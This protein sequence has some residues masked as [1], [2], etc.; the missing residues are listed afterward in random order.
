MRSKK[1]FLICGIPMLIFYVFLIIIFYAFI[2]FI[3][4]L[5][6]VI[7]GFSIIRRKNLYIRLMKFILGCYLIF[8]VLIPNPYYMF[9]EIS[10]RV[11]LD[12]S[13]IITPNSQSVVHLNSTEEFWNY[14][15]TNT[16]YNISEFQALP[17]NIR[18]E[19]IQE[20][21]LSVVE[22]SYDFNNYYVSLNT[23]TPEEVLSRG[24]DDC[25]GQ[26]VV[27][28]SFLQYLGYDAWCAETPFHW[29]TRVKINDSTHLDLNRGSACE[30]LWIFNGKD[31]QFPTPFTTCLY[32]LFFYRSGYVAEF[33]TEFITDLMSPIFMWMILAFIS[34]L[35]SS[36]A[37]TLIKYPRKYSNKKWLNSIAF[38]TAL[39]YV[40]LIIVYI[41]AIFA[42]IL[43]FLSVLIAIFI[44]LL[45][46]DRQLILKIS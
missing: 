40:E 9:V 39:L 16:S 45:I 14:L 44:Y 1:I 10:R 21:I 29:Y 6:V 23:A 36:L 22:Y 41:I 20:F 4:L 17:E 31:I 33:Y 18:L 11:D 42:P 37:I 30:P 2:S 3:L 7:F 32:N 34:L 43:F 5:P 26:C 24:K 27:T 38:S 35:I 28:V 12:R 25:Q 46:L 13:S 19:L 8:F 15:T